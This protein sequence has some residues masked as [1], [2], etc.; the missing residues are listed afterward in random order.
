MR[1]PRTP[2]YVYRM[3]DLSTAH[4]PSEDPDF[5]KLR[6]VQTEYG[7]VV[8]VSPDADKAEDD[9]FPEWLTTIHAAA[10]KQHA[11]IINFDHDAGAYPD[12]FTMY[13]W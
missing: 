13:D 2:K 12:V 4:T 10:V 5:G 3:L 1:T 8:Y 9:E 7:W 6:H 11:M